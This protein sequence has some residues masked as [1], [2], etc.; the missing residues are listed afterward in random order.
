M[1]I[2]TPEAMLKAYKLRMKYGSWE[3][4]ERVTNATKH[5]LE[6]IFGRAIDEPPVPSEP[7][8]E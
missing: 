1:Q 5:S 4:V 8:G 6:V 7:R 2:N 3:E